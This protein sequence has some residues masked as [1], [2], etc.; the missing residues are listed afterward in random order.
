[1][2]AYRHIVVVGASLAGLRA[3]EALRSEGHAGVITIVGAE[4]RA[5]YDR[6]PLSKRVLTGR[7][8]PDE[9]DLPVDAGL[10]AVWRLGPAA[11]SVD[12]DR[13]VV[14][15]ADGEEIAFD[16]LVLATGAH[17]RALPHLGALD[18]IHLLRTLDDAVALRA[19][20]EL[21]PRLVIIGAGFIGLEVA[22][23]SRALGLDVTVVEVAPVPLVA[24]IGATVGAVV[25]EIHREH[26]VDLRL[27][28][29]VDGVGGAD[30]VEGVR[31]RDGEI[32]AADV[33]VVGVGAAPT[34]AWLE[35]SGIDLADGVRTDERLRVLV[36]GRPRPDVVAAGDVARWDQRGGDT[37]RLEHWTNAVEQ[38]AAAAAT[39]LR[40][41]EAAPFAPVPYF[42]SDHYDRKIQMVGRAA[43]G[44]EVSV[45]DGSFEAR[46][47]VAAY[48]RGGRLVAA[49]GVN[50]PAK[51]MGLAR[52]IASGESYPPEW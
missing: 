27:G 8:K 4:A 52:R 40:G 47:F 51:V 31:L 36:G 39:L 25:A 9:I 44:D 21:G 35:G 5:P 19:A 11:R 1:L 38:G 23:S 14:G 49:L 46:R 15:L 13:R 45:V 41:D 37:A 2:P 30:R 26:G 34:T 7:S 20:L 29:G 43:T 17:A 18:G 22:A 42:W 50:R 6:P 48:G 24:A 32:I 16:G 12:L 10:D 3:A 28:A 33:V